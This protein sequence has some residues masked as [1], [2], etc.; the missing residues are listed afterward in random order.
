[1]KI[2]HLP[3]NPKVLVFDIDLT[4]YDNRDYANAQ[5]K[6]IIERLAAHLGL[7]A[8][9]AER[10]VRRVREAFARANLGRKLSTGNVFRCLGITIAT[11]AMWREALFHPEAYL[12]PDGELQAMLRDLSRSFHIAAVT[13]NPTSIG[14]RTLITLGIREYFTPVIGLDIAG[15]SKPTIV[16]FKMVAEQHD[17]AFEEMVSIGDRMDVDVELPVRNGMGGILIERLAD[18]YRLPEVFKRGKML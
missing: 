13:N 11:S 14:E 9:E 10:E 4:L 6:L 12:A 5:T 15:E 18:V 8:P 7:S 17:V 1:M 2:V 16:P 3:Q